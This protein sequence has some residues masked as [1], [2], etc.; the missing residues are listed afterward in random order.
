MNPLMSTCQCGC[1]ETGQV[2]YCI[3]C[4]LTFKCE[5]EFNNHIDQVHMFKC[6]LCGVKFIGD[7]ELKDHIHKNHRAKC[8]ICNAILGDFV[9]LKSHKQ[10][11]SWVKIK[12][13]SRMFMWNL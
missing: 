3:Y 6:D 7:S 8:D 13:T 11:I 1:S 9:D 5:D 12:N 2:C 10:K 4:D